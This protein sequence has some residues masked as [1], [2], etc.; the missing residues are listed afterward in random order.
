MWVSL[1][2]PPPSSRGP[3]P[4]SRAPLSHH[5]LSYVWGLPL[6]SPVSAPGFPLPGADV[7][8]GG[9]GRE[10]TDFAPLV[11]T[12]SQLHRRETTLYPGL[13]PKLR[14]AGWWGELGRGSQGRQSMEPI[15]WGT[16][17]LGLTPAWGAGLPFA[18]LVYQWSVPVSSPGGLDS[19]LH[20]SIFRQW[21]EPGSGF[22]SKQSL[23][24][25]RG[26]F[27]N[28]SPAEALP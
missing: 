12:T 9:L 15:L 13:M 24:P 28:P 21:A 27:R 20:P 6:P 2:H 17:T 19:P 22:C 14:G 26:S 4:S 7:F 16:H 5:S 11:C 23:V 8:R 3:A 1:L 25:G 18:H 10:V